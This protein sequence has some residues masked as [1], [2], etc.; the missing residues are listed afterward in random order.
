VVHVHDLVDFVSEEARRAGRYAAE[1]IAEG[2]S[3]KAP[4]DMVSKPG[5]GLGYIVPQKIRTEKLTD[6]LDLFFRVRQ[7][8]KGVELVI[9]ADG[10]ELR[11]MKKRHMAPGEMEHLTLQT[12]L[13]KNKGYQEISITVEEVAK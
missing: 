2:A 11:R 5:R 7:E 3:D 4:V 1:Y 8:Y 6:K 13:I 10:D 12:E 9:R